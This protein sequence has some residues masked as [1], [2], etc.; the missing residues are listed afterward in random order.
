VKNV[1]VMAEP[2]QHRE[3]SCAEA[4][5]NPAVRNR[6]LKIA[7]AAVSRTDFDHSPSGM[8]SQDLGGLLET[9]LKP[10]RGF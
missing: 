8:F 7:V 10:R 1:F 3:L 6:L 9:I 4:V 2:L 5:L